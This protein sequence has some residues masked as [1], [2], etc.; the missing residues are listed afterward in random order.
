MDLNY[1]VDNNLASNRYTDVPRNAD[2]GRISFMESLQKAEE[3]GISARDAYKNY[4]EARFGSIIVQNVG[5]DQKSMD[6]LGFSTFGTGN[7]VIAPNILEK[8]AEDPE[9]AAYYEKKIQEHFDSIPQTQ[10]FMSAMGH[11]IISSGVVIHSD[12]TVTYYL[13]GEVSPEK[14]AET[15]ARIKAEDEAKAKRKKRYQEISREAAAKQQLERIRMNKQQY[16]AEVLADFAPGS[17]QYMGMSEDV[18]GAIAD[19]NGNIA[20]TITA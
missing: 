14:R 15:E 16:M 9:K 20:E 2:A 6:K 10:A 12:G 19:Y 18:N 11:R 5:K 1:H 3:T 8:M 4:L 7:V 13:C 17:F